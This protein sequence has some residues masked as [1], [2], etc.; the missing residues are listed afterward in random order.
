MPSSLNRWDQIR[1]DFT[2][3]ILI[4]N[5]ASLAV[6][7]NFAYSSL[8]EFAHAP[9][10]K[11]RLAQGDRRAFTI[12]NETDFERVLLEVDRARQLATHAGIAD[13]SPLARQYRRIR[14]AL[15]GAV[16][17]I[18]PRHEAIAEERH[19]LTQRAMR[20]FERVFTTNYDLLTYW[21]VTAGRG[22]GL[23]RF[24]DFFWHTDHRF[25]PADVSVEA[26]DFT[27]VYYL[28]GGLHI[29]RLLDG[30]TVKAS[31]STREG[32]G[33]HR[34]LL[35]L[36]WDY[37]GARYPLFVSEGSSDRKLSA[38]R[39]NE[40]LSFAFT[41]WQEAVSGPGRTL[42]IFGHSLGPGDNHLVTAIR[43]ANPRLSRVA[44]SIRT[45]GSRSATHTKEHYRER[46]GRR[47]LVFFDAASHP[48]GRTVPPP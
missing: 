33:T 36:M 9:E 28:H 44:V 1:R 35:N 27:R 43:S 34:P 19:L 2:D 29:F 31:G 32:W 30:R 5:G 20:Q 4:G 21:A 18:H 13:A 17:E 45:G 47:N 42:T 10:R 37:E 11:Y 14:Q 7:S 41:E 40:Y 15:I 39:S 38:I 46:L 8:L 12:V 48:L 25:D 23:A 22:R 26:G 6:S 16:G 3:S 24:K